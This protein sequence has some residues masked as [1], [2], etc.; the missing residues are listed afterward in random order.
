MSNLLSNFTKAPP[1]AKII[2]ALDY[3]NEDD[4]LNLS[5]KLEPSLCK[6][7]VGKELFTA[8]GPRIVEKLISRGYDVFLDLKFH[9]IPTTVYKAC[10]VACD[11]GVWMLNVHASGG[12][13]MLNMA[14]EA[15]EASSYKPLLIAVTVLTSMSQQNLNQIGINSTVEEQVIKLAKLAWNNKFDGV[16]CSALEAPIIKQHTDQ[17]FLAVT[18]GIRLE[19]D[20]DHDQTRVML[21]S[22]A[23]SN[24]ADYLVIGRPITQALDPHST[25]AHLVT[26]L[27]SYR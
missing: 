17:Y 22:D 27:N 18:P 2:V 20:L 5:S 15:V 14:F 26:Q 21:P 4:A 16:V 10:R 7:K 19:Q 12:E 3:D 6:L 25:L 9:D 24:H 11:L 13:K 23:V 1:V 8:C